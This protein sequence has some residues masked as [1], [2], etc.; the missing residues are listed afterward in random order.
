MPKKQKS[1]A[2]ATLQDLEAVECDP[3]GNFEVDSPV[4]K[5]SYDHWEGLATVAPGSGAATNHHYDADEDTDVIDNKGKSLQKSGGSKTNKKKLVLLAIVVIG[6]VAIVIGVVVAVTAN[7][8]TKGA[9]NAEGGDSTSTSTSESLN[10]NNSSDNGGSD[11]SDTTT[12]TSN[13]TSS[14]PTAAPVTAAPTFTNEEAPGMDTDEPTLAPILE[15]TTSPTTTSPTIAPSK[16]PTATPTIANTS[17]PTIAPNWF[18]VAT[19]DPTSSP[20]NTP[21]MISIPTVEP[22]VMVTSVS[23]TLAATTQQDLTT[24]PSASPTLIAVTSVPTTTPTTR[25][26]SITPATAAPT[27]LTVTEVPTSNASLRPTSPTSTSLPTTSP[28][29]TTQQPTSSPEENSQPDSNNNGPATIIAESNIRIWQVTTT[30]D[31]ISGSRNGPMNSTGGMSYEYNSNVG[32]SD[33]IFFQ[34][35]KSIVWDPNT[36]NAQIDDIYYFDDNPEWP[37]IEQSTFNADLTEVVTVT[38]IYE[39]STNGEALVSALTS[40]RQEL[41]NTLDYSAISAPIYDTSGSQRYFTRTLNVATGVEGS[42]SRYLGYSWYISNTT[43]FFSKDLTIRFDDLANND[44]SRVYY[45][46]D[47]P[48]R[49]ALEKEY[50]D[51]N[52]SQILIREGIAFETVHAAQLLQYLETQLNSQ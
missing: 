9:N 44:Y 25:S 24:T 16:S 2:L 45:Y 6:I 3:F 14:P 49:V 37:C 43:G 51:P 23:P 52:D 39:T 35:S 11:D 47:D 50:V 46:Q 48:T 17:V 42:S 22:T 29:M 13:P 31:L 41:M 5:K 21:T 27:T 18:P 1:Q 33:T 38:M 19:L 28:I 36:I 34:N 4:T 7:N 26:P 12:T 32:F 30:R 8:D 20:S 40:K 15:A 10:N